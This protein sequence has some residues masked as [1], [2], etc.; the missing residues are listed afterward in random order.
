MT[1]DECIAAYGDIDGSRIYDHW[2]G[3]IERIK[4]FPTIINIPPRDKVMEAK[5]MLRSLTPG[6]R[7]QALKEFV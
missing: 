7:E 1:R 4:A 6:Q 3:E 2:Q 5:V